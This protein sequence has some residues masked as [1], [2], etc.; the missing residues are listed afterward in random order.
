MQLLIFVLF[1]KES[2]VTVFLSICGSERKN[3]RESSKVFFIEF[4]VWLV[5]CVECLLSD[6][7]T[8]VRQISLLPVTAE[9]RTLRTTAN[10]LMAVDYIISSCAA[11][12]NLLEPAYDVY[13]SQGFSLPLTAQLHHTQTWE[14]F[15]NKQDATRKGGFEGRV[16]G[17]QHFVSPP[18][19]IWIFLKE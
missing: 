15:S 11:P 2:L 18:Y 1:K 9:L 13:V 6:P 10:S 17:P 14:M 4:L 7:G 5:F 19:E 3:V 16:A 12:P 8:A